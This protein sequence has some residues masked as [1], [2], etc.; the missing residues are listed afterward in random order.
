MT[1]EKVM[2]IVGQWAANTREINAAHLFGS[3]V[4]DDNWAPDQSDLDIFVEAQNPADAM[5]DHEMWKEK[6]ERSLPYKVDIVDLDPQNTDLIW[7]V[8]DNHITVFTRQ[9]FTTL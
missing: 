7:N 9:G 8:R 6:L 1:R 5:F 3:R 2:L 4:R